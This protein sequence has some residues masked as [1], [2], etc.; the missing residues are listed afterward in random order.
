MAANLSYALN[1]NPGPFYGKLTQISTPDLSAAFNDRSSDSL[2]VAVGLNLHQ[3]HAAETRVEGTWS[4]RIVQA[5][6]ESYSWLM[7]ISDFT[8]ADGTPA[9]ITVTLTDAAGNV[10]STSV[11]SSREPVRLPAFH[12]EEIV[13]TVSG[14]A[15]A[16]EV[17]LASSAQELQSV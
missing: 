8:D 16:A 10:L 11:V 5:R 7:V 6:Y 15:R 4:R 12:T 13:V 3:L 17:V 14:K 2:Y 1:L 9:S